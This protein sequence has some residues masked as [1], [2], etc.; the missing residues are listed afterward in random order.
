VARGVRRAAAAHDGVT[1]REAG[2]T[3]TTW[4]LVGDIADIT[5]RDVIFLAVKSHALPALLGE[6]APYWDPK[7]RVV[8]LVNG[9]PWWYFMGTPDEGKIVASVAGV[10]PLP[11]MGPDQVLGAVVYTTAAIDDAGAVQIFTDQRMVLGPPSG[12]IDPI[13]EAIVAELAGTG[14]KAT[15]TPKIRDELWTKVALNLA[16]NP[17]S[18]ATGSSLG[19][20]FT[21]PALRRMVEACLDETWAIGAAYGA[22]PV[23]SR[24]AMM[25]LGSK[26][27]SFRTSM[28]KDHLAGRPLE[29]PAIFDAVE[30]LGAAKGLSLP[31]G[32]TIADLARRKAGQKQDG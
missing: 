23:M 29:L 13:A 16:T 1:L 8:P 12:V 30:E 10:G 9:I 28:L 15:L 22:E 27:G 25:A 5:G 14:I 31:V 6:M 4:P 3:I 11:L 21:D 18:V 26:A 2:E 32:R 19:G 7:A 20:M 24:E 17:L